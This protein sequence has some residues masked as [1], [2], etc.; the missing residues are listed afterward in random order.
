M[1]NRWRQLGGRDEEKRLS[2]WAIERMRKR[3]RWR[4]LWKVDEWRALVGRIETM[5]MN[6]KNSGRLVNEDVR[7]SAAFTAVS[8]R[9]W[10]E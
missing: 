7:S 1:G 10:H 5:S 2:K 4:V 8:K 6:K 9:V 3:R